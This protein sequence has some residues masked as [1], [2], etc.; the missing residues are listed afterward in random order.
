MA[1]YHCSLR[2]FSRGAGQSAVAAAAYR[3]ACDLFDERAKKTHRY[4]R[5]SGVKQSFI[6]LPV[7]APEEM[8]NR[9][10]LWNA[11]EFSETRK[12]SRVAREIVL[13]LPHELTD[14]GRAELTRDMSMWL[15]E[16][17]GVAVDGAIHDPVH[18]DDAR[19]HHAHL[20]FT[21]REV[22][23]DGL[24]AKTRVLDNKVTGPEETEVIREV[25]ETLANEAL[26]DA[27]F[28]DI[29]IDRRTLE[30]QG[31]DRIPQ[32]HIGPQASHAAEAL[33]DTSPPSETSDDA[34]DGEQDS[35]SSKSGSG[36]SGGGHAPAGA[37][38]DKS[39]EEG[40]DEG[41][42]EQ[43][44]SGDPVS[45]KLQSKPKLDDKGRIID[46]KAI[47]QGKSRLA[48]VA[49]IKKLNEQR[50][51]FGEKP[52]KDQIRALD[53]LM[54]RLDTRLA[55]LEA[56]KDKTSLSNRVVSLLKDAAKSAAELFTAREQ[57]R[58]ALKLSETEVQ[59]R[60]LRQH[61][62]YG[63]SYRQGLHAQITNMK[64]SMELLQTK[65]DQHAR[66]RAFVEKLE[67]EIVKL[68]PSITDKKSKK[69]RGKPASK[70]TN[71]ESSLKLKLKASAMREGITDKFKPE[72]PLKA[73]LELK[74]PY[75]QH[76]QVKRP[77]LIDIKAPSKEMD[78]NDTHR[79][80][81]NH[82]I[83]NNNLEVK[84][85]AQNS[86]PSKTDRS[87]LK[88]GLQNSFTVQADRAERLRQDQDFKT[89]NVAT[90]KGITKAA[91]SRE[92]IKEGPLSDPA[93]YRQPFKKQFSGLKAEANRRGRDFVP[94]Q[95]RINAER[96][97]AR[98]S[99]KG[100]FNTPEKSWSG[101]K[102]AK[103]QDVI[104]RSKGRASEARAG[105]PPK[106]R[107]APYNADAKGLQDKKIN[108]RSNM[109]SAWKG[110][111]PHEA[112]ASAEEG[113]VKPARNPLHSG[114]NTRSKHPNPQRQ[115]IAEQEAQSA[116]ERSEPEND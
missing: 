4:S 64:S 14:A 67:K 39:E 21:T 41:K 42:G 80:I 94:S 110:Q 86:M 44:G 33:N 83:E 99:P 97:A 2:T 63:R 13:A 62:R 54:D 37:N 50:A 52:L 89:K 68:T 32:T 114:F 71:A 61:T 47:D 87:A 91:K 55:H 57:G 72:P 92:P 35:G 22:S 46:Y 78:N 115:T 15:V 96:G 24:G 53:K 77:A 23:S 112:S 95:E 56:L 45:L 38:E 107:A 79:P 29:Q 3:S 25:W 36:G 43:G 98:V 51:A 81:K 108:E 82:P 69:T 74:A 103:T 104:A 18:G 73:L 90:F 28:S 34:D 11:A 66:Y 40:T 5:K 12:N 88:S 1:I 26:K 109:S 100:Q 16:R 116:P 70:T 93:T 48:F 58:A 65:Q 20:L 7:N 84:V 10:A 30:D 8:S 6:L 49:E 111:K 85:K 106:Y 17:Y 102:Q 31:I 101:P 19:N 76:V 105:V 59:A 75:Q 113:A 60:A 9:E 27:G